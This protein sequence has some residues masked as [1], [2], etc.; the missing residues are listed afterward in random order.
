MTRV[1]ILVSHPIQYYAPWF[2]YLAKRFD[3]EVHYAHRVDAKG[4]AEA[5]FGVEFDWDF[6]ESHK[7]GET[8]FA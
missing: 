8:V 3:V 7:S 1:G 4:Q 5:G 6:I 2:R